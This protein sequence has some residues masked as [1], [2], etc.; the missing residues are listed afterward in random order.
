MGRRDHQS[1]RRVD[2]RTHVGVAP[3]VGAPDGN[4]AAQGE[5]RLLR[6]LWSLRFGHRVLPP[7]VTPALRWVGLVKVVWTAAATRVPWPRRS[8]G[9]PALLRAR[10][11][12][13]RAQPFFPPL[14]APFDLLLP[15]SCHA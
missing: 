6:G 2:V 1:Q 3:H 11:A 7:A 8:S 5:F 13:A 10:L 15:L 12:P 4:V 9:A 14:P